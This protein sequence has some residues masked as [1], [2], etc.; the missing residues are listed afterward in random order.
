MSSQDQGNEKP[1]L[2]FK[3]VVL[4]LHGGKKSGL[5]KEFAKPAISDFEDE[6]VK[7]P[8]T[9]K[10]GEVSL[11]KV[12][13]TLEAAKP[14]GSRREFELLR[15]RNRL[16]VSDSKHLDEEQLDHQ[17]K[18][19]LYA[20]AQRWELQKANKTF[21]QV[22][23]NNTRQQIYALTVS[24]PPARRID[25]INVAFKAGIIND[26]EFDLALAKAMHDAREQWINEDKEKRSNPEERRKARKLMQDILGSLGD[27]RSKA[28]IEKSKA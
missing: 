3:K 8:R 27:E 5:T 17:M 6:N 2:S 21:N 10:T 15:L 12:R 26:V 22:E 24:Q 28:I 23:Y 19:Q 25:W 7:S 18:E 1:A 20:A 4:A 13:V 14:A 11:L 9:Y 16:P